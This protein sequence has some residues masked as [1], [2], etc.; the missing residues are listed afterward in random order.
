LPDIARWTA[1]ETRRAP[2]A[3]AMRGK[4]DRAII[5]I[6]V[7]CGL[8][9]SELAELKLEDIQQ[10]DE[11]WVILDLYGKGGHI[12][13][14]PVPEWV[15]RA[16]DCWAAAANVTDGRMFRCVNWT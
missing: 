4:R 12:R 7:G 13:T 14:V 2:N 1:Q 5:A 16:V 9:R 8:R 3:D 11:R 6:L 15:K 10:R